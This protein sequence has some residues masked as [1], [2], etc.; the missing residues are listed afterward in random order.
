ML[1]RPRGRGA[2][3]ARAATWTG[4]RPWP[5]PSPPG[6]CPWPPPIRSTSSTPRARPAGPRAWC[7]TTA[8]TPWRSR[9]SM[10]DDLRHPPRRGRSGRRRTSAGWWATPTSS[11]RPL[12]TGCTT[13]LYEGKPVGTPDP[14]RVLAGHLA[15]RRQDAVHRAHRVPGHQEG[16]PRRR[17]P[18]AAT[19]SRASAACSWPASASTPTPTTGP[20]TSCGVPVIDHWWQTETG[21]PVAANC[22]GLERAAGEAGLAHQA[23][24]GLRRAQ[25]STP[26]ATSRPPAPRR[27]RWPSACRCRPGRLPTLWNDDERYIVCYLTRLRRLLHHRRRRLLRR[28]RLPLRDGAHRRRHQRGRPPAVDRGDG[29]GGRQAPRRGRVRGDRR[30]RRAEGPGAGGSGG[31]EGRRRPRP[32]R[33]CSGSWWRA[34]ARRSAPVASF[35][36]VAVVARLPKTRSG[37]DPARAPC[38]P[39]P[40]GARTTVPSTIDDPAILDELG[41]ALQPTA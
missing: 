19:T 13:I 31:A 25:S 1:Q 9:R 11:T 10:E 23:G 20:T 18:R 21:W 28:G 2:H 35:K 38:G 32:P 12:L 16:G 30:G 40:T 7:A 27:A 39:S 24:A 33:T 5:P 17:A 41:E 6:A 15:A 22:M 36:R 8:A 37:Q 34:C 29:G 3:G 4:T 26:R 14:G